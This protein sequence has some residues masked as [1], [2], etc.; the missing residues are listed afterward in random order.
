MIEFEKGE[1]VGVS[2]CLLGANTRYDGAANLNEK[3]LQLHRLGVVLIPLCPE[4]LGGLPTPRSP[5]E[6]LGDRVVTKEG[7]DVT[8]EF[9]RGAEEAITTLQKL[10]IHKVILKARSPSCGSGQT[11][12]G[13]F[14]H[15]KIERDGI[16]A[17][18]CKQNGIQVYSEEEI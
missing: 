13:T 18:L 15:T 12:D 9:T 6:R 3:V 10:E 14:T 17:E 2:F 4:Q 8:A 7:R 16:F 1:K 5:A 11:Y